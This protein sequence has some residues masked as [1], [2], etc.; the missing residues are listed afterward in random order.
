MAKSSK[1]PAKY[2]LKAADRKRNLAVQIGLTAV[3]VIFAVGLVLYIVKNGEAKRSEAIKSVRVE[4]T[5]LIKNEGT[6]EPKVVLSLF[7]DFQCPHCAIFEQQF[8]PTINKLVESGAV[9]ADYYML[10]ILDSP[11]NQNYSTRAA[12]AGY[13]VAEADT[14]PNKEVF[15]RFHTALFAQQPAENSADAPD[16][17]KL[18]EIARQAGVV[19][20]VPD[21][22]NSGK[23][24]DIVDGLAGAT[25]VTGTPTVRVNGEDFKVSTPDALI[26]KVKEIVGD[27]PALD[28]P[29][30]APAPVPAP[31]PAP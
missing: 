1:R 12:N 2:D 15:Q 21:C 5:S 14:T 31:A 10:A 6:E 24:N 18:I 27:V 11:Q 3:V 25:K 30:P 13:C 29:A 23:F 28:A 17:A 19:G 16:N 26:A 4:S 22:V 8:G 9:A 20:S 7:E